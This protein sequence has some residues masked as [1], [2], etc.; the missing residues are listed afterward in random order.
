MPL[1]P[2]FLATSGSPFFL[3]FVWIGWPAG[4]SDPHKHFSPLRAP[5]ARGVR[6]MR[7]CA[8]FQKSGMTHM[9]HIS[10]WLFFNCA[11]ED[12]GDIF[13]LK[14]LFGLYAF[15]A[16]LKHSNTEGAGRRQDLGIGLQ[17]L[18]DAGL[19]DA[20]ANLLLHPG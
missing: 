15:N 17:G 6:H 7:F 3:V 10:E 14:F 4:P 19:I 8:L 16:I 12:F 11:C 18:I 1:V 2:R 5:Q 9:T 13:N 20:F